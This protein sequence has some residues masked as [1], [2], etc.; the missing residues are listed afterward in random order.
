LEHESQD[1]GAKIEENIQDDAEMEVVMF[2]RAHSYVAAAGI[3][4]RC[5]S[6]ILDDV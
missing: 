4:R 2:V 3:E 5:Q 1:E 6:P